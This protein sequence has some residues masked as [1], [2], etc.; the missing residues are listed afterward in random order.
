MDIEPLVRKEV[1]VRSRA[2]QEDDGVVI[3]LPDDLAPTHKSTIWDTTKIK[4]EVDFVLTMQ[5]MKD[6]LHLSFPITIVQQH[7]KVKKFQENLFSGE[8]G[9]C[10][11]TRNFRRQKSRS[12]PDFS[13][14]TTKV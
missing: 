14:R 11:R 7:P 8:N 13:T 5:K 1:D 3:D 6:P 9:V 4:Y 2:K 10:S 12:R